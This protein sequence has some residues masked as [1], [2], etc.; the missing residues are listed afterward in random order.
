[1]RSKFSQ[2]TDGLN[3]KF[4]N[5][6]SN[7]LSDGGF[8]LC[9]DLSVQHIVYMCVSHDYGLT[10]LLIVLTFGINVLGTILER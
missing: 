5:F 7:W 2:L 4:Y 6:F 1:M 8:R 3:Q 10:P 9:F